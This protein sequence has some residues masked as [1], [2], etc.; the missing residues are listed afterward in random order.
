MNNTTLEIIEDFCYNFDDLKNS[1]DIVNLEELHKYI[2]A[3]KD[4]GLA[5]SYKLPVNSATSRPSM[6]HHICKYFYK[7]DKTLKKYSTKVEDSDNVY[8]LNPGIYAIKN[9]KCTV[10]III[11]IYEYSSD[12][13]AIFNNSKDDYDVEIYFSGKKCHNKYNKFIK[14]VKEYETD[15]DSKVNSI[16]TSNNRKFLHGNFKSFDNLI[17]DDKENIIKYIDN[18]YRNIP[19]YYGYGI[20]PKLSILLYGEPGTG[21]SSFYEAV[22]NHL[23]I[24]NINSISYDDFGDRDTKFELLNGDSK[25]YQYNRTSLFAIDEIDTIAHNRDK[26][27]TVEN[28]RIISKLLAFLDNPPTSHV[29]IKNTRYPFS[30]VIATTNYIDRLDPAI[31]REGRFDLKIE[32]KRINEE[33]ARKLCEIYSLKLEDVYDEKITKNFSI[34]PAKLQALCMKNIDKRLKEERED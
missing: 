15:H 8:G 1:G 16:T 29:K 26:D 5:Y 11:K 30:I 34:N 33:N 31:V 18:W 27:E 14:Y 21:K 4:N 25:L 22:A 23:E 12:D 32:M 9:D 6:Y 7:Y 3:L 13:V 2:D 28:G 24:D 10:I 19:V 20:V 17:F